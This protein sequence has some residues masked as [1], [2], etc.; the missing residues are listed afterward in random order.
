MI[1]QRP[2]NDQFF[3]YYNP[4][5]MNHLNVSWSTGP[6]VS[7]HNSQPG[8]LS[9]N[10]SQPISYISNSFQRPA[11][12]DAPNAPRHLLS[13]AQAQPPPSYIDINK[14]ERKINNIME[15]MINTNMKKMMIMMIE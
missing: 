8:V 9:R 1:Y 5:W 3:P 14:I 6:N 13:T 7:V 10:N 12:Q 2:K 4:G 11:F 15:M